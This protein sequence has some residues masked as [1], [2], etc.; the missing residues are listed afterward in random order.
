MIVTHI[1]KVSFSNST[2][3]FLV[4]LTRGL[5]RCPKKPALDAGDSA[6][7]TTRIFLTSSFLSFEIKPPSIHISPTYLDRE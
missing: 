1:G 6:V 2:C 7:P 5:A 4:P 3:K